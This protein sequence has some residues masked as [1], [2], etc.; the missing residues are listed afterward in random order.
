MNKTMFSCGGD[1]LFF[2]N[3]EDLIEAGLLNK[4]GLK[5]KYIK[6]SNKDCVQC[7]RHRVEIYES[8]MEVCEKCGTDQKT[9]KYVDDKYYDP[10]K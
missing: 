6:Y 3:D 8:G 9:G 4:K 1:T 7:G 5:D 10:F 2:D